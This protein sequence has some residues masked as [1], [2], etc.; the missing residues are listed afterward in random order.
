MSSLGHLVGVH[1]CRVR[2]WCCRDLVMDAVLLDGSDGVP[3][4]LQSKVVIVIGV[5]DVK[6]GSYAEHD[7]LLEH[8]PCHV[9][10]SRPETLESNGTYVSC[11]YSVVD[12]HLAESF[13]SGTAFSFNALYYETIL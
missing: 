4:R 11:M 10:A 1:L 12:Q 7:C 9:L 13:P 2:P 3:G 6:L 8:G 5:D